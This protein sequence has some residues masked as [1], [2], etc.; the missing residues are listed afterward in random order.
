MANAL[1]TVKVF[2][3]VLVMLQVGNNVNAMQVITLLNWK[4]EK[5]DVNLIAQTF[6]ILRL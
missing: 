2:T 4:L 6:L 5:Q 3:K 1:W